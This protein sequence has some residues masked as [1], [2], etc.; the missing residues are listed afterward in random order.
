MGSER[1]IETG[2]PG[3]AANA[4]RSAYHVKQRR[5]GVTISRFLS[6]DKTPTLELTRVV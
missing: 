3:I 6:Q 4:L 1:T 2:P 5:R